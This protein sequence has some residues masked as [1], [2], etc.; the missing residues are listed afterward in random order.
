MKKRQTFAPRSCFR[1]YTVQEF[2]VQIQEKA[3]DKT[4][5]LPPLR[6]GVLLIL[7]KSHLSYC[8]ACHFFLDI[9]KSMIFSHRTHTLFF[10]IK[11]MA[12]EKSESG[13]GQILSYVVSHMRR[14]VR[15]DICLCVRL[16]HLH[17]R[18]R[19]STQIL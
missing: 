10:P 5:A 11:I 15:A 19:P 8:N 13:I 17:Q 2:Y 16:W 6:P 1:Q 3:C 12:L 4:S 18:R 14:T 9:S 7:L